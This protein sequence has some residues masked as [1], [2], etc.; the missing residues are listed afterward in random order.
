MFR[1][2]SLRLAALVATAVVRR[3]R[4]VHRHVG[5]RGVAELYANELTGPVTWRLTKVD[6]PGAFGIYL[7]PL[8]VLLLVTGAALLVLVR[9]RYARH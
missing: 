2:H 1:T 8:G 3:V 6:C 9:Q 4:P 5:R 7:V